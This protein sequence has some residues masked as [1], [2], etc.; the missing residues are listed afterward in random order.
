MSTDVHTVSHLYL[1]ENLC[2]AA[3][4]YYDQF[5]SDCVFSVASNWTGIRWGQWFGC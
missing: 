5:S 2:L 3:V 1:T 4:C